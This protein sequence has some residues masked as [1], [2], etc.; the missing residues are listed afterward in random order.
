M[1]FQLKLSR[2]RHQIQFQGNATSGVILQPGNLDKPTPA[3]PPAISG[4]FVTHA[5]AINQIGYLWL[6][7]NPAT[8]NTPQ[9]FALIRRKAFTKRF[10]SASTE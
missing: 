2:I 3:I 5:A 6:V 1:T 10:F 4:V 9:H 7:G 8:I